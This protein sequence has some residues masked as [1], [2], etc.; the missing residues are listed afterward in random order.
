M[1]AAPQRL[2]A[3]LAP[4]ARQ[5]FRQKLRQSSRRSRL[6][7]GLWLAPARRSEAEGP[8]VARNDVP[9]VKDSAP[10]SVA[11][12]EESAATPFSAAGGADPRNSDLGGDAA[13]EPAAGDAARLQPRQ[14]SRQ[15]DPDA[16][17]SRSPGQR[18]AVEAEA[19]A[20]ASP[21]PRSAAAA[22]Q[23]D[24][25]AAGDA[26]RLQSLGRSGQ[27]HPEPFGERSAAARRGQATAVAGTEKD[28]SHKQTSS[29]TGTTIR[30][31]NTRSTP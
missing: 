30:P 15:H 16:L 28:W 9:E 8:A 1:P 3:Q 25:A 7:P 10:L 14:Q 19:N 18:A 24:G 23:P 22:R 29:R 27:R 2:P 6:P 26:A 13:R 31:R 12:P 21:R 17:R 5:R 20:S 4:E 11:P